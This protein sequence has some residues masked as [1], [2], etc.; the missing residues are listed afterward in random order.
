MAGNFRQSFSQSFREDALEDTFTG[1]YA[2]KDG[3][4]AIW[5]GSAYVPVF[6]KGINMGI[7][8]PGT[9]PGQLAASSED[10]RRWFALIKEAGYNTI[11]L[12]TMHYPRFYDELRRF[13]LENPQNPLLV[14]HGVWLE[15]NESA[16][17]LFEQTAS[18]SQEIREVVRAVHGD[19]EIGHRF[20]KAYGNFVSD[21]SPWVIAY[22]PGREIFPGE[23]ALTNAN[24][25]G[26]NSHA[27][28]FFQLSEA[29]PVEIWLTQRLDS[30]MIY[31]HDLYQTVRPTGFSS[32]PTLDPIDHPTE[33][34][35]ADSEEDDEKIDLSNIASTDSS[36]GFFIG[37]HAY[38]Y[39][40]DF[41]VQDPHYNTESDSIGP[42]SYLAYLKALKTHYSAIPLL[43]AEFG[44]PSSLGSG[45]LSPSGMHH[46]GLSEEETGVYAIRIL[47]NIRESGCSGGFQFSLIDEW[48]KQTWITNP[49]SD[50]QYRHFWHNITTPEQNF[51]ILSYSPPPEPFTPTGSFPGKSI[52]GVQVHSDYTF[53]RVRIHMNTEQFLTDTLWLALDTYESSLGESVMP[54]GTSIGAGSDTLRAEFA[55]QIPLNGDIAELFV[56]PGYDVFGVKKL[57][58]LDTLVS[59]AS[60]AGEWNR[61]RWK[62]NY[63]Y[64]K[65]QYIGR[66]KISTEE[67]PYHFLNTVTVYK[68]SL[69][70]RLPWT[71][72][73]YHAPTVRRVMHYVSHMEGNDI[74]IDQQDS[75]SD[76][77][78]LTLSLKDELYRAERYSWSSWDYEK[79]AANPPLER[80]KQSFHFLRR[81]LPLFNSPPIGIADT[82]EV[83]P[84]RTLEISNQDGLLTNDFDID[85]NQ[86]EALLSFGNGTTNG[87]LHLHPDGSFYYTP[88]HSF[89]GDDFFMY[90][91]D[92]S[93]AYS[94]KVPVYL[95][96]RYPLGAD[97]DLIRGAASIFPNPGNGRFCIEIPQEFNN[98]YLRVFDLIGR[99]VAQ[100]E[101]GGS[102]TWVELE[103]LSPGVYLFN[104]TIDQI[105]EQHQVII[106]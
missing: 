36:G 30:L 75:L 82:F 37:Y 21:I 80:K 27:G 2:I 20:G 32:W 79:I 33:Q 65:T 29:D 19:I 84:G 3:Q 14:I 35:I 62:T 46:G 51:G 15:E 68:D 63:S 25:P 42:N 66:L 94:T 34:L 10:Y 99:E 56:I 8:V 1:A 69:D 24:N 26:V 23:V 89:V 53:F 18:F 90:Y 38:P 41:I 100:M 43:I 59:S 102:T 76:G 64:N 60:D 61:V 95:N 28:P 4:F 83:W 17:D 50:K 58:R 92:D 97:P 52:T 71:L 55:L 87:S 101:I 31:E 12:Y 11:R 103:S 86:I 47:D 9:Q 74:V 39:Y 81:M 54:D 105:V 98:S 49:Y 88:D 72:I 40:P 85:G 93:R 16:S 44:V 22:L 73:N 5:N 78:A 45:H 48:F 57:V 7:S 104:L 6:I 70:I 96:V 106:H 91:L 77:I 67:D 13:N